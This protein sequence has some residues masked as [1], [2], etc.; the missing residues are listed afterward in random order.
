MQLKTEKL[1]ARVEKFVEEIFQQRLGEEMYFHNLEHTILV[2]KGVRLIAKAIDLSQDDCFLLILSA[3]LHDI[4]Y[5]QNYIGHEDV[6]AAMAADFLSRNNL[7]EEKIKIVI[8]CILATKFPQYPSNELEKVI[9]DAD[10]YHFSLPDYQNYA[11]RLKLEWE[12]KLNL[13]YTD[14]EWDMLNLKMLTTHQY[15]TSYGKEILQ[16]KK[17]FNIEK[18]AARIG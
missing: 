12:Q 18:I 11:V 10:F 13:F 5:T 15:F 1:L 9:C 14:Q 3:L 7:D 16:K 8:G 17:A 4:G 6:S 2:V